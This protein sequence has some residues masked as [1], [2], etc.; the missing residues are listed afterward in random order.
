MSVLG[1]AGKAHYSQK[2]VSG[3]QKLGCLQSCKGKH[4]KW[5]V[6]MRKTKECAMQFMHVTTKD[7]TVA[8]ISEALTKSVNDAN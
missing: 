4:E 6:S 2:S 3:E 7:S 1:A 8:K 5:E